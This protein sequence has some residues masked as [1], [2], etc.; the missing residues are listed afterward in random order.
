[1][2]YS[3]PFFNSQHRAKEFIS[4]LQAIKGRLK[5]VLT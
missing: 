4:D 1:M 5:N 3:D 2:S